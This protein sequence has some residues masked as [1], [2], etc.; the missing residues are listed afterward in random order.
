MVLVSSKV[1]YKLKMYTLESLFAQQHLGIL[2]KRNMVYTGLAPTKEITLVA[3]VK[4]GE[5]YI[6]ATWPLGTAIEAI[7]PKKTGQELRMHS[8]DFQG[9]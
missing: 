3:K 6:D 5:Y 1:Q 2:S 7:A 9:P 4:Y 8:L